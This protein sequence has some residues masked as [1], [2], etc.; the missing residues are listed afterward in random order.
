MAKEKKKTEYLQ[1]ERE[2]RSLTINQAVYIIGRNVQ[3]IQNQKS[4]ELNCFFT[5]AVETHYK[6]NLGF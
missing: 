5:R 6:K 1:I 4:R 3:A 2:L